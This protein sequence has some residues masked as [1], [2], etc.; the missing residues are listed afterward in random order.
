[1]INQEKLINKFESREG[2]V[3]LKEEE[4]TKKGLGTDTLNCYWLPSLA[5]KNEEEKIPKPKKYTE[6][7]EGKHHLSLKELYPVNF[8]I[9]TEEKKTNIEK[10]EENNQKEENNEKDE[11]KSGDQN[12]EQKD[13]PNL[14]QKFLC[15]SCL[16]SLNNVQGVSMIKICGHVICTKCMKNFSSE[17]CIVCDQQFDQNDVIVLQSEGSSFSSRS[18]ESLIPTVITPYARV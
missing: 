14:S 9:I 7:P 11:E 8:S 6:C 12:E 13:E 15:L 18:G 3:V 4:K 10:N 5:P 17:N 16:K 2:G 1:M